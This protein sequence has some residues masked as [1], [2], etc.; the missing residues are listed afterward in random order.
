MDKVTAMR[1][2]IDFRNRLTRR[3]CG[4]IAQAAMPLAFCL[5]LF[6][7]GPLDAA[8]GHGHDHGGK[9]EVVVAPRTEA[10]IGD[11]QL[12]LVYT[13]GRL[14]AFLEGFATGVPIRGAEMEATVN[15]QPEPLTEVAPGV[16]RSAEI[17][18]SGGGNEIELAWRAG[19]EDGTATLTLQIPTGAA[20]AGGL[21][22]LPVPKV[23]GWVF[24]AAALLL[25]GGVTLLFWRRAVRRRP[26]PEDSPLPDAHMPHAAE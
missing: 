7:A 19:T 4:K 25:Y 10:R 24:L 18:L 9:T 13:Q 17:A 8:D 6:A 15:F 5:L 16:Y 14:V 12:V 11:R 20:A 22:S 3:R 26:M 1:Q 2:P 21:D 23:P